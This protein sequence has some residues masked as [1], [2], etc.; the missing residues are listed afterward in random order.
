MAGGSKSPVLMKFCKCCGTEFLTTVK[1]EWR[2]HYCSKVCLDAWTKADRE[3]KKQARRRECVAC[4]V[5]FVARGTQLRNGVGKYCS[6]RC[7]LPSRLIP[8][9]T[10]EAKKRAADGVRKAVAE[11]RKPSLAGELNARWRGGRKE[12]YERNKEKIKVQGKTWRAAN[13]EHIKARSNAYYKANPDKAR[14]GVQNRRARKIGNGGCLS[15]DL[16][17][18]LWILQRG[19]CAVCRERLTRADVEMDHIVPLALRGENSDSN[20]QLL[21]VTCNRSK[22]AKDPVQFMQSLGKLL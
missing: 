7:S 6:R 22:G 17:E 2:T 5:S 1:R 16:R 14:V 21:C 9:S 13:K 15:A 19:R 12:Y 10:P 3:A 8:A 18:K 20:I 11:G 4:G